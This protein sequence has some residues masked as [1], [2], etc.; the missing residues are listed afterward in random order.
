MDY[1]VDVPTLVAQLIAYKT[2][3]PTQKVAFVFS[4][5]GARAAWFGGVLEAVEQEVRK[6]Q[7]ALA[8]ELR[9]APD[10]LVGTS[11]GAL[12]GLAYFCDLMNPGNSTPYAN[13]QTW[14]WRDLARDNQAAYAL[15][16][17]AG[18]LEI[19]SGSKAGGPA[20][21]WPTNS[22]VYNQ[23][24][25]VGAI[26][27]MQ[28]RLS[29]RYNFQS[30][31]KSRSELWAATADLKAKWSAF[32]QSVSNLFNFPARIDQHNLSKVW[33]GGIS[34]IRNRINDVNSDIN[35]VHGYLTD[36][37]PKIGKAL[38]V[39]LLSDMGS[40]FSAVFNDI[41]SLASALM[42]IPI[43]AVNLLLHDVKQAIQAT[44]ALLGSLGGEI[45]ALF[46][47][48]FQFLT[49]IDD[50]ITF[51]MMTVNMARN[52]SALMNTAG[53]SAIVHEVLRQTT[54]AQTPAG[55]QASA[56][57]TAIF[58][59]WKTRRVGKLADPRVRA[60]ELIVTASNITAK[61]E[62]L[63][64]LCDPDTQKALGN[65]HTWFIG[66]DQANVA[67]VAGKLGG[68]PPPLSDPDRWI[69]GAWP[70]DTLEFVEPVLAD[71]APMTPDDGTITHAV[72][73]GR[74]VNRQFEAV[75]IVS[76][77]RRVAEVSFTPASAPLPGQADLG[78][79]PPQVP[80][81][82]ADLSSGAAAGVVQ[83]AG[84]GQKIAQ[85][86]SSPFWEFDLGKTGIRG[87][88]L[89]A[90]AALTSSTIPLAFPP[91]MWRFQDKYGGSV[92]HHWMI[93][94]GICDN[95]PIEQAVNAGA[96]CIVSFELT[97]LSAAIQ[98]IEDSPG[99]PSIEGVA[100]EG[101][102]N[103]AISSSFY[104]FLENFVPQAPPG[105]Q[106]WRIAP[107]ATAKKDKTV[108]IY[109]FN[110]YWESGSIRTGLFDWFMRGYLDAYGQGSATVYAGAD[111]LCAL[112]RNTATSE[113]QT[114]N[115]NTKTPSP[116]FFVVDF[117]NNHPHPGY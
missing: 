69:F 110:G 43:D 8:P 113:G 23:T 53:L 63:L 22:N 35:D 68:T 109:D 33:D 25:A 47:R 62:V 64:G 38:Q 24:P 74:K 16:D 59:Y 45:E 94:G 114:C 79:L 100:S 49:H 57:D 97:P 40:V 4:G 19:V 96:R 81:G 72:D 32:L 13:R 103:T 98:D 18:V 88:S 112:Y 106:M 84:A 76:P 29:P 73:I 58:G 48:A 71:V 10:I 55:T 99:E 34:A 105:M 6:Q 82:A 83:T 15:L 56:M 28:S 86:Y 90:A 65:S 11:G 21:A 107:G 44:Q 87:E 108:G 26:A 102:I 17:N 95:R 12:A 104:R 117:V 54:P 101:L 91:K 27:N 78:P 70:T 37:P 92:Y 2:A 20:I 5:G 115:A 30:L 116:G 67:Y 66:L 1:Y 60:P 51:I 41:D 7:P 9:F 61:R 31:F 3:N 46:N 111:P 14:L 36:N 42:S 89:I 75:G 50:F 93:D 80:T 85:A 52:H 39:N 77:G